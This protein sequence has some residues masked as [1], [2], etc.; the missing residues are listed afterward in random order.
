MGMRNFPC[1]KTN[2]NNM[3]QGVRTM[4]TAEQRNMTLTDKL[5]L[6][7]NNLLCAMEF[8]EEGGQFLKSFQFTVL[9]GS[10]HLHIIQ[11][12]CKKRINEI[13]SQRHKE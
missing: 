1:M 6:G 11:E 7:F 3:T 5:C 10:L 9:N 4:D 8:K 2:Q 12:L 13:I